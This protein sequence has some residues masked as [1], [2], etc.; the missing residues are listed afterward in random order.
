LL[1]L[2]VLRT[3]NNARRNY[4][5]DLPKAW[6]KSTS[7]AVLHLLP[8]QHTQHD[9]FADTGLD[10]LMDLLETHAPHCRVVGGDATS[11]WPAK[12]RWPELA[13]HAHVIGPHSELQQLASQLPSTV[14]S[15]PCM[16]LA[17]PLSKTGIVQTIFRS[18]L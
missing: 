12:L 3:W 15:A 8:I 14:T 13:C 11:A 9:P 18:S 1:F 4:W 16:A 10:H 2:A 17:S 6:L 5:C 7:G